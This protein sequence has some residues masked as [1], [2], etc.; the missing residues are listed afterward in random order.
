VRGKPDAQNAVQAKLAS[1]YN[2]KALYLP[3]WVSPGTEA[4]QW[5]GLSIFYLLPCAHPTCPNHLELSPGRMGWSWNRQKHR[6]PVGGLPPSPEQRDKAA[7]LGKGVKPPRRA[8]Y[9]R[10][11]EATGGLCRPGNKPP[12]TNPTSGNLVACVGPYNLPALAL[13]RP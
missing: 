1:V 4:M 2:P 13:I 7:P 11:L 8:G 3:G 10:E 12:F 5:A 6:A 9:C